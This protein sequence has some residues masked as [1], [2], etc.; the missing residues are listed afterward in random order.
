MPITTTL[1]AGGLNI[2]MSAG[3]FFGGL[4]DKKEGKERLENLDDPFF[5]IPDEVQENV[6]LN[7]QLANEGIQKQEKNFYR[8]SLKED[9]ANTISSF[10]TRKGGMDGAEIVGR[11]NRL[12]A[13]DLL[14]ADANKRLENTRSLIKSKEKMADYKTMQFDINE[15]QPFERG[16]NYANALIGS[17]EQNMYGA[18][19]DLT[20]ST[21][22]LATGLNSPQPTTDK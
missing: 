17:G 21:T 8:D 1:I 6:D 5:E 22:T 9:E 11:N 19:S 4:K 14:I 18:L 16:Y 7:Q 12:A 15:M 10:Q 3:K 20:K 2:G 13:K